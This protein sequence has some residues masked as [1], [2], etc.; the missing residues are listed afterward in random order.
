MTE[1][2]YFI[3]FIIMIALVFDYTNGMHDAA[4][5]IATIVSTRVLTPRQ[6][7]IWAAFFN[8]IAFVV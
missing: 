4:N 2:L 8:F 3:I 1:S 5:S 7:V 6:A